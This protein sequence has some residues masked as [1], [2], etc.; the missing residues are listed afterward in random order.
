MKLLKG[1]TAG[2]ER[3][4]KKREGD[5]MSEP[6]REEIMVKMAKNTKTRQ[7]RAN[8]ARDENW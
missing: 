1:Q 8:R 7:S 4:R 2:R 5:Q 3:V 6:E